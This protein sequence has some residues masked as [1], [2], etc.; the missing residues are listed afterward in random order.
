MSRIVA[1]SA[2]SAFLVTL[3]GACT[4][5]PGPAGSGV[6]GSP[7]GSGGSTGAAGT[8]GAAGRGGARGTLT[9]TGGGNGEFARDAGSCGQ[10]MASTETVPGD[11]LIILDKSGSM[12]NQFTDVACPRGMTCVIKWPAMTTA[13]D[14]VVMNTQA[15]INWGLKYFSNDGTCGAAGPAEI[16]PAPNN[17][18]TIAASIGMTN[19]GGNTPT[20]FAVEAGADYMRTL[21]DPNPKYI[22]LATDGQPNCCTTA[23]GATCPPR[24][25][26]G[27]GGNAQADDPNAIA[28]V[29]AA[30]NNGAGIPV[31]VVGV[32]SLGT[33]VTTLNAMAAAGGK[34]QPADAMGRTYFPA[35]DPAGLE[36]A[37]ATI[38]GQIKSC[39]FSLSRV[40]P[41]PANIAVLGDGKAIPADPVNGWS[42]G[43]GM[44]SLVVNGSTCDQVKAGTLQVIEAIFGCPDTP[45]IIP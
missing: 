12:D 42:Y 44:M 22:L 27:G 29:A 4:F 17:A 38:S 35:D 9:G 39:T 26:N 14:T 2:G 13:L 28:A 31:F 40:P 30:Y 16:P 7:G 11:L 45:I 19:P 37:L 15:Q 1:I 5:S 23:G 25:G 41:V 6:T 43:P 34:A 18:A 32:G 24:M 33:A 20:R 10:V 36:A 3:A 8:A 21:T